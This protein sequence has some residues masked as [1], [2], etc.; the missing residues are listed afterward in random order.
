MQG[1]LCWTVF[2]FI[3]LSSYVLAQ[4]TMPSFLQKDL[5][6]SFIEVIQK[7]EKEGFELKDYL[8]PY[9]DGLAAYLVTLLEKE[10]ALVGRVSE[11]RI[12]RS[13]AKGTELLRR[14]VFERRAL[15][16]HELNN[17]DVNGDGLREIVIWK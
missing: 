10:Q 6:D 14:D 7:L 3:I 15:S 2:L 11:F 4:S 5:P 16:F 8:Y 17:T 9:Q 13:D 1:R 12:Y